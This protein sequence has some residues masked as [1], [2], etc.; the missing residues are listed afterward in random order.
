MVERLAERE[1]RDGRKL[2]EGR[3]TEGAMQVIMVDW[4]DNEVS[5]Q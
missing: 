5:G 2:D 3:N 4:F 1:A